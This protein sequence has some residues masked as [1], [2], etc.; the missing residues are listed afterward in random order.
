MTTTSHVSSVRPVGLLQAGD[1]DALDHRAASL[2]A[3]RP[4]DVIRVVLGSVSLALVTLV[5]RA[6]LLEPFD[7][8]PSVLRGVPDS[9]RICVAHSLGLVPPA[10]IV[11]VTAAA[12]ILRHG[13]L[14]FDA[15]A[16]GFTSW[17]AAMG[18]RWATDRPC[19]VEL[20]PF[21]AVDHLLLPVGGFLLPA[22]AVLTALLVITRRYLSRSIRRALWFTVG[23]LALSLFL[24]G[25][26]SCVCTALGVLVGWT[27][28]AAICLV[29]GTQRW[30]PTASTVRFG[31][32]HCGVIADGVERLSA[33]ARAS[34]PFIVESEGQRLFVKIVARE[35]RDA[36]VLNR[37]YR[38]L[39]F[40]RSEDLAPLVTPKRAVEHEAYLALLAARSGA[41]TPGILFASTTP[42]HD[43]V[44][45]E[46]AIDGTSLDKLPG[47]EHGHLVDVWEQVCRLHS[48]RIAHRDLR[49][50][51]VL[52]DRHGNAW[53][54]DFGFAEAAASDQ[55]LAIDRAELL[56]SSA[57]LVGAPEAVTAAMTATSTP[58]LAGAGPF[59]QPSLL[60]AATRRSL[61]RQPAL[62][63]DLRSELSN[64]LQTSLEPV[65][66]ALRASLRVRR[67]SAA[68]T[69]QRA[70]P[71]P[72]SSRLPSST[73]LDKAS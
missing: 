73:L 17:L 2:V 18:M 7:R 6:G 36:D 31:L 48:W 53:I 3:R 69:R 32:E 54:L 47:V 13:R 50:A 29:R 35:N 19:S 41:R 34:T 14:A 56:V 22:V 26:D 1:R 62:L 61:R 52:I 66:P 65:V 30:T 39:V 67:R 58:A 20:L 28:G 11:I 16:G 72:D 45:V 59:L 21:L 60:S 40:R 38:Y 46:E 27:V 12:L 55:V 10:A 33:D 44:L 37:L 42:S 23:L 43:G 5:A 70:A 71:R 63:D 24:L 9:V 25:F 51:N 49:L 68:R 8:T 64:L 4:V 57:L 15:F